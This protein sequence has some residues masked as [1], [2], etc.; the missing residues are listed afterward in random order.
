LLEQKGSER[1]SE[2]LLA[3]K[4]VGQITGL[5]G[6]ALEYFIKHFMIENKNS[7]QK[8]SPEQLRLKILQTYAFKNIPKSLTSLVVGGAVRDTILG[9]PVKDID[10]LVVGETPETMREKGYK[11]VGKDFPVF[12]DERGREFALAR[13]E[14]STGKKHTDFIVETRGVTVEEDLYRR[15]LTINA[16]ALSRSGDLVDP[17]GGYS[18]LKNKTSSVILR[19]VSLHFWED[20]LRILRTARQDGKFRSFGIKTN[21]SAKFMLDMLNFV[22]CGGIDSLNKERIF[23]EF[24]KIL[25]QKIPSK[26]LSI[27]SLTGVW[28][29]LFPN[30]LENTDWEAA[31]VAC[32]ESAKKVPD[33][34]VTFGALCLYMRPSRIWETC[35]TLG[36]PTKWKETALHMSEALSYSEPILRQKEKLTAEETYV[37]LE[38]LKAFSQPEDFEK[39]LKI[40]AGE[41]DFSYYK[42]CADGARP[43]SGDKILQDPANRDKGPP[44]PW[45]GE[46]IRQKRIKKIE[47]SQKA[48][49]RPQKGPSWVR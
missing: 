6:P 41:D 32:D 26:G 44:G 9:V 2:S 22:K 8:L 20:P 45:V 18:D 10:Y 36:A 37:F 42:K 47:E 35:K 7:L 11:E 5:T 38:K 3:G 48:F 39:M 23:Q 33:P 28:E 19:P 21:L 17:Y 15:D 16:I 24:S 29:R 30:T 25:E 46:E 31:M 34:A 27:L 14:R 13:T 4:D 1:L 43:I 49:S 12:L 40:V